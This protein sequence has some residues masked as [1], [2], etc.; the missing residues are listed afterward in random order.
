MH[1]LV[2]DPTFF[3][4]SAGLLNVTVD[5]VDIYAAEGAGGAGGEAGADGEPQ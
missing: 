3:N 4:L 2:R 5:G 1:D